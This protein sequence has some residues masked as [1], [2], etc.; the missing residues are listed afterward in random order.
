MLVLRLIDRVAIPRFR[1]ISNSAERIVRA[2]H[3]IVDG[4]LSEMAEKSRRDQREVGEE[5]E[6]EVPRRSK[7][8]RHARAR[9]I[10]P[11]YR[12]SESR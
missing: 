12:T 7:V 10:F 8:P 5:E 3:A 11:E 6:E 4:N 9:V 1:D 2:S